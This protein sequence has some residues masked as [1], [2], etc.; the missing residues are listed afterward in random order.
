MWKYRS[1]PALCDGHVTG[2]QAHARVHK[3][4]QKDLGAN[5]SE[6]PQSASY[7]ENS[8]LASRWFGVLASYR[9]NA[10]KVLTRLLETCPDGNGGQQVARCVC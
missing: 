5:R 9:M 8:S 1:A 4:P 2:S 7:L 6:G 10:D 3:A